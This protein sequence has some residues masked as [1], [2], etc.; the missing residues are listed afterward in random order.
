M[1]RT[2]FCRLSVAL[3]ALAGLAQ[4]A[5]AQ[6]KDGNADGTSPDPS[7]VL[8]IWDPTAKVAYTHDTGKT[9]RTLYNTVTTNANGQPN[10]GG[11]QDFLTL[12]PAKD[13]NFAQFV[14]KSPDLSKDYWLVFGGGGSSSKKFAGSY[15][16]YTTLVNTLVDGQ[17][18]P[19]WTDLT[20]VTNGDLKLHS[21]GFQNSFYSA[22]NAAA[23]N[24]NNNY[25]TAA[26]GTGSSFET[27]STMGYLFDPA[28]NPNFFADKK[29][30]TLPGEALQLG[31][32]NVDAGNL[33][34]ANGSSSWFYYLTFS[35]SDPNKAPKVTQ[36]PM[37]I[38]A[39]AN[40]AKLAYWGLA[41]TTNSANQQE[42]VLSFTLPSALTATTTAAGAAR[43]NGTDYIASYGAAR[44]IDLPTTD[45]ALASAVI[46]SAVPEPSSWLLMAGGLVGVG[47]VARRQQRRRA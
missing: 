34:G 16:M 9:G 33:I 24:L 37:A 25:A 32:A 17:V 7:L 38:S 44:L 10:T 20:S 41:R 47:A 27:P 2:S 4:P 42:L 12:D 29:D 26:A 6:L 22:F 45:T 36:E 14:Q 31:T 40:T 23:G 18:N 28:V 15:V 46:T 13:S 5:I 3:T 21:V 43:R 35:N 11:L 1:H 19:Q 8:M 39:F 30:S